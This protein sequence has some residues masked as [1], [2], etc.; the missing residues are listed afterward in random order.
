ML[1]ISCAQHRLKFPLQLSPLHCFRWIYFIFIFLC[2]FNVYKFI[3]CALELVCILDDW[4]FLY[5]FEVMLVNFFKIGSKIIPKIFL[6]TWRE[7]FLG[8]TLR[9]FQTKKIFQSKNRPEMCENDKTFLFVVPQPKMV[10]QFCFKG[11]LRDI[12][13]DVAREGFGDQ[14]PPPPSTRKFLQLARVFLRKKSENPPKFFFSYKK[15]SN[16]LSKNFWLRPWI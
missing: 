3:L 6:N 15:I 1:C 10:A 9:Q 7:G 16:P 5:D 4:N 2:V 8:D 13:R 12:S 14:P 11:Y